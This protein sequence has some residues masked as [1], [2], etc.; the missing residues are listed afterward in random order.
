MNKSQD[1]RELR[2]QDRCI[3]P[4]LAGGGS[5]LSA[6]IGV[7]Q[8]IAELGL[9]YQTL[10]GVSGGSIVGALLA[11]GYSLPAI[12]R[13][14]Q[15]TDFSRFSAQNLVSLL[16]TGGLS[17]GN[18]FETWVDELVGGKTFAELELDYHVV[19]TDVRTGQPVVFSRHSHP[20]T[21][22]SQAVRFSMS[23]PILFSFKEYGEHLL[24]DGSILSEEALQR[25]W[26][27]DGTPVVVFKLRSTAPGRRP[28]KLSTLPLR[29]YLEMLVRTFMT[30][31]SREYIN[32]E[33]WLSTIV[34]ET[35]DTSPFDMR[36][37]R[38]QKDQLYTA[39][40]EI[41]TEVLPMKLRRRARQL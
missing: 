5:R 21:R 28:S 20:T 12:R 36:L 7:M 27:G 1:D 40:F 10:V 9:S 2:D 13:I 37:T 39:G 23:V 29:G 14:A 17:N 41:T 3:V 18:S 30:T 6:H 11:A 19:A 22:V 24:V 31:I 38:E 8:A 15:D 16:R 26:S 35:G 33:F 4:V 25:N 32:E 34:I